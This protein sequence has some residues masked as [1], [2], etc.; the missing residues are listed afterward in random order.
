MPQQI[1]VDSVLAAGI[2]SNF[3][4]MWRKRYDGVKARMARVMDLDVPSD[5]RTETYAY[6]ETPP[7]PRIWNRGDG[8]SYGAFDS[9]SWTVTNLDWETSVEWHEDDEQ[10][11]QTK[12]L[13]GQAQAAGSNFATLDE[14]IFY[15]ILNGSADPDLLGSIPNSPDGADLFNATDGASAD[16]FG[17]SGGNIVSGQTLTTAAGIRTAI[18][19]ACMGRFAAFQDTKG[20]PLFDIDDLVRGGFTLFYPAGQEQL[21][22]EAVIQSLSLQL[23]AG[24]STTDTTAAASQ[25]N[26]IIESGIRVELVPSQR[27]SSTTMA[28]FANAVSPKPIFRQ[29]RQGLQEQPWNRTN[30]DRGREYKLKGIGWDAR[31]GYGLTVPIGAIQITA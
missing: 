19:T 12:S 20:Q 27:M 24:T 5:K 29:T 31:Y 25:S 26:I 9:K 4:A 13:V 17:I 10:D 2:R 15:Q 16:R 8:R 6:F 14:R 28:I 7:Y 23:H 11:D 21:V 3:Y 30:S 1:G 22:R 18:F